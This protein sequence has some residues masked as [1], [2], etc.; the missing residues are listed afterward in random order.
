MVYEKIGGDFGE[1]I[2]NNR[3]AR[4]WSQQRLADLACCHYNT[5]RRVEAGES[6]PSLEVAEQIARA[7][8]AEI[9][10]R[11]NGREERTET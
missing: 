5:L 3:K 9:I 10:I 6:S 7:F 1:W 4:K 11:E 8:G 2:K